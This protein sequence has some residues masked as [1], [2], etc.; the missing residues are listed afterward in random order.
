MGPCVRS[1]AIEAS[2]NQMSLLYMIFY[3]NA[4]T[5][6]CHVPLKSK[7]MS[8]KVGSVYVVCTILSHKS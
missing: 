2:V 6:A 4:T 3:F 5:T 1:R 7:Y 8:V